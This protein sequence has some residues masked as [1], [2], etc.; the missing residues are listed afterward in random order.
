MRE[1]CQSGS[2]SGNRNQSQA[3]PDCGG[4]A[5]AQ[6]KS[7]RE[8]KATAPVLDS[9]PDN[10]HCGVLSA[11]AWLHQLSHPALIKPVFVQPD[12]CR[13]ARDPGAN[14]ELCE[15]LPLTLPS[16]TAYDPGND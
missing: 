10:A 3:Q 5:K 15:C 12:Y 9:T 4:E 1:I 13:F 8:A 7:H 11:N 16:G 6:P 14:S 2:M